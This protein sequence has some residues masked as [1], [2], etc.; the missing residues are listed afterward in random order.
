MS[1]AM[2]FGYPLWETNETYQLTQDEINF[3]SGLERLDGNQNCQSLDGYIFDHP[4]LS[5]IKEFCQNE[6]NH[7]FHNLMSVDEQTEIY[8]TQ[9]WANYNKKGAGH[10]VHRHTNSILSAVFY[11]TSNNEP[12][13]LTRPDD[14]DMFLL[15]FNYKEYNEFNTE[16]CSVYPDSGKM[17][18]FPST[19]KHFVTP[20][21][22]ETERISIAMNTFVKG[23]L[24]DDLD[25][26][27]LKL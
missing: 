6:I 11:V 18:I 4:E 5:K 2:I 1:T 7:Y 22:E 3:I 17:I 20:N 26:T 19:L 24:G 9:S 10:R 12:I 27:G 13:T 14:W 8:I 16:R 15:K 23:A 25:R 21:Q